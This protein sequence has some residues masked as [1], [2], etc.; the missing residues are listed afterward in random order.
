MRRRSWV[1]G[2]L[3]VL[4]VVLGVRP[5]VAASDP[6]IA[7]RLSGRELCPRDVCNAVAF[8]G[9][10]SGQPGGG[11]WSVQ[12]TH[13]GP[14]QAGACTAVT[15]GRWQLTAGGRVVGGTVPSGA[16]CNTSGPGRGPYETFA[17]S[18]VLQLKDGGSGRAYL[19]G[20]LDH[21][22]LYADP[23]LPPTLSGEVTQGAP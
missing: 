16:L 15:G 21:A 20:R 13:D 14:P 22:P 7:G 6:A 4:T 11:P 18:L 8:E 9:T 3:G 12:V 1:P 19:S 17:L 2:L 10:L 5:T 23:P